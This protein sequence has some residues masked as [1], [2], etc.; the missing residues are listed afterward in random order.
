MATR[1]DYTKIGLV[2]KDHVTTFDGNGIDKFTEDVVK[3]LANEGYFTKLTRALAGHEKDTDDEKKAIL[4][5][6]YN[7]LVSGKLVSGKRGFTKKTPEQILDGIAETAGL[8]PAEKRLLASI[9]AKIAK[10]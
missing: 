4:Q 2:K 8:T 7:Q 3:G 5:A 6:M 9:K 1:F 10:A